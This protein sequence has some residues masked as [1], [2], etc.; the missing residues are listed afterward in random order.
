MAVVD[1][2]AQDLIQAQDASA[3]P[4]RTLVQLALASEHRCGHLGTFFPPVG[5]TNS[6]RID[7]T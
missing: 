2:V 3:G 6:T 5:V 1:S 4:V 7:E